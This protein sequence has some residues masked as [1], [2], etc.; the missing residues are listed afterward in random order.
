[1]TKKQAETK[2]YIM[3]ENG[4]VPPEDIPKRGYSAVKR[5]EEFQLFEAEKDL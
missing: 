2:L 1:M 4:E 5:A 3:W